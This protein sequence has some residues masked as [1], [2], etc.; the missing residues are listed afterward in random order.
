LSE[1]SLAKAGIN[2]RD[3]LLLEIGFYALGCNLFI[4]PTSK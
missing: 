4:S 2:G 1:A 3:A